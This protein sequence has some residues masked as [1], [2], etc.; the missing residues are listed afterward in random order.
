MS[1]VQDWP[2]TCS[3]LVTDRANR[4]ASHDDAMPDVRVYHN[5]IVKISVI[6]SLDPLAQNYE[7]PCSFGSCSRSPNAAEPSKGPKP[8][9]NA[10]LNLVN[11]YYIKIQ[12][13]ANHADAK[14]IV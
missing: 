4:V 1:L 7:G 2:A 5:A 3:E 14:K 8:Y 6:Q 12:Q 13:F 11:V 10:A 9:A